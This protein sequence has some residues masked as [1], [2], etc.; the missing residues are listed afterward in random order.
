[1]RVESCS[2]TKVNLLI[3]IL[4]I[5][6][7]ELKDCLSCLPIVGEDLKGAAFDFEVS[8]GLNEA[9][10]ESFKV[11]VRRPELVVHKG[12]TPLPLFPFTQTPIKPE[13]LL[14]R[15]TDEREVHFQVRNW[16]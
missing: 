12:R 4:R 6:R 7:G 11:G 10:K 16:F 8:D 3:P 13:N 15:S 2:A 9:G 5:K 14:V 1:M